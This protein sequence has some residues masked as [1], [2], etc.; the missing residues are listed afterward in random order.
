MEAKPRSNTHI[1]LH[2]KTNQKQNKCPSPN[3]DCSKARQCLVP[4]IFFFSSLFL[5]L[6]SVGPVLQIL[7][8]LLEDSAVCSVSSAAEIGGLAPFTVSDLIHQVRQG[9]QQKEG[10]KRRPQLPNLFQGLLILSFPQ[11]E[12][13]QKQTNP[14]P[15]LQIPRNFLFQSSHSLICL[16]FL[17]VTDPMD[18]P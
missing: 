11:E 16:T 17:L 12:Q 9:S 8:S 4:Y 5:Y 3:Y 1:N 15:L 10:E 2:N 18:S 13:Q 6:S 14:T 7:G